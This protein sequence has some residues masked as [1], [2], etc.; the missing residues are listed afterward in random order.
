MPPKSTAPYRFGDLLALAR[1]SWTSQMATGLRAMGY[2]EYRRTDAAV[3]RL[4]QRGPM[5][6]GRL[7][8]AL[9]VTRQ[10]GR[11]V[12]QGL[13]RRGLASAARDDRDS[14][15]VNITLS[16][17]GEAYAAAVVAVIE[18]LNRD[19][20]RRVDPANLAGA[21]A[22]LRAVLADDRTRTLAAYLGGPPGVAGG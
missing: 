18:H 10:A 2:E 20:C 11:K 7:G 1:Q 3:M 4:L 13:E 6:V 9:G 17:D 16:P 22:V 15:Q 12:A 21:D 8:D 14:R 5:S 19:L